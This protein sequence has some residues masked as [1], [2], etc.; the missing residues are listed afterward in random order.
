[1]LHRSP[2]DIT[3][4]RKQSTPCP[5]IIME[6]LEDFITNWYK[7][8]LHGLKVLNDAALIEISFLKVH[9]RKGCPSDISPSAGTNMNE[10]FK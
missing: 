7:C 8:E 9:I 10:A 1:M 3:K 5:A 6:K 2:T 4:Q